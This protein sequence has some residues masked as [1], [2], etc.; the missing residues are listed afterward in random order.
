VAGPVDSAL[1]RDLLEASFHVRPVADPQ[2]ALAT[3]IAVNLDRRW[4]IASYAGE[5]PPG[6]PGLDVSLLHDHVLDKLP[7]GAKIEHTR[8]SIE[9]TCRMLLWI[10]KPSRGR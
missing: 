2:E 9:G 4:Y 8:N 5:R 7:L 6:S 3:A 1:V 10:V